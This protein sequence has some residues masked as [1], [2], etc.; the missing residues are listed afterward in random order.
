MIC[1]IVLNYRLLTCAKELKGIIMGNWMDWYRVLQVQHFADKEV[2]QAAYKKLCFKYHPDSV[3]CNDDGEMMCKLNKAYE[4]LNNESY[5]RAY[6]KEW[7]KYYQN[8]SAIRAGQKKNHTFSYGNSAKKVMSHYFTCLTG[9]L[10]EDAY[11]L[12]CDSDKQNVPFEHFLKWQQCVTSLYR[13]Y[14]YQITESKRCDDFLMEGYAPCAAERFNIVV[15]EENLSTLAKICFPV[16]KFA[17]LENGRWRI[18]LG[19]RDVLS[20]SKIFLQQ[21]C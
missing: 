1:G 10:Y 3:T 11:A 5:R 17:I 16:L 2:I 20:L 13:I 14:D 4:V 21:A 12:L 7:R 18:Y 19:Y 9:N 6:D 15:Y 8:K